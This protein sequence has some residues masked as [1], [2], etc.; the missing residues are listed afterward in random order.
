MHPIVCLAFGVHVYLFTF[1]GLRKINHLWKVTFC[2]KDSQ[3]ERL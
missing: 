3:S 2:R 1:Y